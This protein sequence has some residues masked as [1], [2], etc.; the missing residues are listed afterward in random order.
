MIGPFLDNDTYKSGVDSGSKLV[1][2]ITS[3]LLKRKMSQQTDVTLARL[4]VIHFVKTLSK[5]LK[6]DPHYFGNVM[7]KYIVNNRTDS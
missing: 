1:S 7:T 3:K 4:P 6:E 2:F 5:L